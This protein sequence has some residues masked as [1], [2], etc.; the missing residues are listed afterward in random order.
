MDRR[1]LLFQALGFQSVIEVGDMDPPGPSAAHITLA[2]RSRVKASADSISF[3]SGPTNVEPRNTSML[4][5]ADSNNIE[6]RL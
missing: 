1:S 2:S 3:Q 4:L 5:M 6:P